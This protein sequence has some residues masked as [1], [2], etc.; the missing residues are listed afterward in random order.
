MMEHA[1]DG[2]INSTKGHGR[3]APCACEHPVDPPADMPAE[4][5]AE[6]LRGDW[7]ATFD[8]L[9]RT[10]RGCAKS[11]FECY[12]LWA[13]HLEVRGI[14]VQPPACVRELIAREFGPSSRGFVAGENQCP[15]ATCE[16][17]REYGS[18]NDY[19]ELVFD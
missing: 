4:C 10:A 12:R 5:Q 2:L 14:R 1:L 7:C 15:C 18:D 11:R 16:A 19:S 3:T 9:D 17:Y 13:K 8:Q 6:L